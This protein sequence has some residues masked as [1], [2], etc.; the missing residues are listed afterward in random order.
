[1]TTYLL[2]HWARDRR[3]GPKLP[4]PWVVRKMT[5]ETAELYGLRDRGVLAPGKRGDLNVID[6][7]AL[8]LEAPVMVR[9]LPAGGRRF[10]QRAR[11]YE[12]TIV[13]GV[14]TMRGGEPTGALPGRLVRGARA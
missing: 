8:A 3:R 2:T 13:G 14:A 11:G 10:V 6:F 5:R 7:D 12:T 9:D 1:M 4:L